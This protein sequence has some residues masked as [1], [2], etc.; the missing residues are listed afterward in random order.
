MIT[1]RNPRYPELEPI[2]TEA[3]ADTGAVHT[4]IPEHV[5]IQLR[6][7]KYDVKEATIANGSKR[8]LS[9]VGPLEIRFKNRTGLGGALVIGNQVLLGAIS[10]EDMDLVVK[11]KDRSIDVNPAN[12]NIA[13]STIM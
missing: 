7:E 6:L 12:P 3:L 4:C 1:L 2:P 9:Y 10:M 13:C 5:A 11:P 8:L